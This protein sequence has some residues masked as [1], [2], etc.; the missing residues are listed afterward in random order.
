[1]TPQTSEDVVAT[2]LADAPRVEVTPE[3]SWTP[4]SRRERD[5]RS[6]QAMEENERWL[7]KHEADLLLEHPDWKG[8]WIA[9]A[10]CTA[11][12]VVGVS[13]VRIAALEEGMKSKEL[14]DAASKEH[15]H[16]GSM[17][18]AILLGESPFDF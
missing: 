9:V 10:H 16:P 2:P 6:A 7:D 15:L 8:Q 3:D 14:I 4:L 1:M 11:S 5:R 18:T 13:P 12:K 17:I